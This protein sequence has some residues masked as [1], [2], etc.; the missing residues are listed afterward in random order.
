MSCGVCNLSVVPCRKEPSDRSEMVTQL[1]FGDKF[2]VLSEKKSWVLIRIHQDGY[3]CWIDRKQFIT[4]SE[5][6]YNSISEKNSPLTAEFAAVVRDEHKLV[7][8]VLLG[9]S[10][11]GLHGK[12][13]SIDK[14]KYTYEGELAD[15]PKKFSAERLI[16]SA[17]LYLNA[18][19]LWGGKTPFGTD[20]SGFTQMVFRLNGIR[21]KRDAWQ[22]SEQG[23]TVAFAEEAHSGDLAFFDN[24]AGKIVHTGI[25]LD[26]SLIIHASGKVRVDMLDHQGIYDE[27][28]KKYTHH[29]RIIRRIHG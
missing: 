22:Q 6:F 21:L 2:E 20:C 13:F 16:E 25:I 1:L 9:S 28:Q 7:T 27:E 17:F 14:H 15:I 26:N 23:E 3:E 24:E 8:P 11:P 4:V 10:I 19:Y 12:S 5:K 18:P 29:L